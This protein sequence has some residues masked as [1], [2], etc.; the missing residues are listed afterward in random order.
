MKLQNEMEM[1]NGKDTICDLTL[2]SARLLR[3]ENET[4]VVYWVTI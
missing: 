1:R 2:K 3:V 4:K